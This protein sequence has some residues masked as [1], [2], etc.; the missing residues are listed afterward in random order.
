[1]IR[2]LG[3]CG[4]HGLDLSPGEAAG[5]ASRG[6]APA[7]GHPLLPLCSAPAGLAAVLAAA[8]AQ[9]SPAAG[10]AAIF[11]GPA[12]PPAT[13]FTVSH[14]ACAPTQTPPTCF[15]RACVNPPPLAP[16]PTPW[17]RTQLQELQFPALTRIVFTPLLQSMSLKYRV[18]SPHPVA[19]KDADLTIAWPPGFQHRSFPEQGCL[20]RKVQGLV[21]PSRKSVE[22]HPVFH[23]GMGRVLE[24]GER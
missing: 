11:V 10:A 17:K 6:Q 3:H 23:R 4:H 24:G 16:P 14:S 20:S 1:M 18:P 7:Q 13:G 9:V 19:H 5:E 15:L 8:I 21:G 12:R 2:G 22:K